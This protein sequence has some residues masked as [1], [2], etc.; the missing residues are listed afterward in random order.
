MYIDRKTLELKKRTSFCQGITFIQ[1]HSDSNKCTFI[2]P[3]R[4]D[5]RHSKYLQPMNV[6]QNEIFIF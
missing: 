2:Q 6:F 5:Q 3:N 4:L 1:E